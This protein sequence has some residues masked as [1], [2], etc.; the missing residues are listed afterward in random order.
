[1]GSTRCRG[2][3]GS[4]SIGV[5]GGANTR[6]CRSSRP[7]RVRRCGCAAWSANS[8]RTGSPRRRSKSARARKARTRPRPLVCT[9]PRGM[10][11]TVQSL[12]WRSSSSRAQ[13]RAQRIAPPCIYIYIYI[14][15]YV[16]IYMYIHIH[17][18]IY[19]YI[20]IYILH[21][22]TYI[23]VCIQVYM[24]IRV[25]IYIYIYIYICIPVYTGI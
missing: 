15:V 9:F 4:S 25:Y 21:I 16:Y 13:P 20:Y 10:S 18:Y 5:G 22:Y 3:H 8:R 17:I 2:S 24:Y 23:Y 14:Y 12:S 7:R 1:M 11:C 19:I 6:G